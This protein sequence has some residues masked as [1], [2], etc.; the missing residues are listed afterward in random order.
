[1]LPNRYD[2]EGAARRCY[3]WRRRILDISQVSGP[4]HIAPSFSCLEMVDAVYY[5]LFR[6]NPNGSGSDQF[7]MSKGHSGIAQYVALESLGV[8][9]A[10]DLRLYCK[11]SGRLGTHPALD[12]PGIVAAT[13]S[14][15][16]GLPM[17]VGLALAQHIQEVCGTVYVLAGDG[18]LQE[19]SMW[20]SALLAANLGLSN[21]VM[22]I[23]NN[24]YEGLAKLSESHP[25]FYPLEEKFTAFGWAVGTVD[26]HKPADIVE[27]VETREVGKPFA[28]VCKTV[29]GHGVSFMID[30]PIWHYRAPNAEEYRQ[31]LAELEATLP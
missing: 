17:A 11:P 15:G 29:K 31:A 30:S 12:S 28:L 4:L 6:D 24:D 18:E 8:I 16:H 19:G 5:G 1:M 21:L 27:A 26:G 14:L 13:G 10:D 9:S 23:D 22:L 3:Q 25:H 7:L 2:A 20:E